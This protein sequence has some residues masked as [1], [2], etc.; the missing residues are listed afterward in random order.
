MSKKKQFVK[1][2]KQS[3]RF[4]TPYTNNL[5]KEKCSSTSEDLVENATPSLSELVDKFNRGQRLTG[6]NY[7]INPNLVHESVQNCDEP[8]DIIP[9]RCHDIVD[10]E[11][12]AQHT[13]ARRAAY[14]KKQKEAQAAA[15]AAAAEAAAAK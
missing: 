10:V 4:R 11:E 7:G 13:N 1:E 15:E 12:V 8:D 5:I 14:V 9:V 2:E 3:T 6:V